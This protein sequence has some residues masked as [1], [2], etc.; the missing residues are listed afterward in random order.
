MKTYTGYA[1]I[2]QNLRPTASTSGTA[3]A[4]IPKNA[5]MA[6]SL[7]EGDN[8]WLAATYNGIS[9]FVS[10]RN[11][12]ILDAGATCEVTG[13]AAYVRRTPESSATLL[14]MSVNGDIL[15]LLDCTTV[16]GWYRVSTADG[17]GWTPASNL[18][19]IT[20]PGED[21]EEEPV[22][23]TSFTGMV[24]RDA[25]PL[26]DEPIYF[27]T[28]AQDTQLTV[29]VIEPDDEH[30][31]DAYP[32]WFIASDYDYTGYIR[33]RYIG[34]TDAG[35]TC[36]V[37]AETADVYVTPSTDAAILYAVESGEVLQLLDTQYA[38]GWYRV[39]TVAGTGWIQTSCVTGES[40]DGSDNSGSGSEGSEGSEGET[41]STTVDFTGMS[42]SVG[43]SG[44]DVY[45]Y[46]QKP[47]LDNHYYYGKDPGTF[48]EDTMWAVK[49]FQYKN[50]WEIT[51]CDGVADQAV[52]EKLNGQDGA[53]VA[54]LSANV[55]DRIDNEI[56]TDLTM[57]HPLWKAHPFDA[58]NTTNKTEQIGDSGNAPAAIAIAFSAL[59]GLAITPPVIC[60]EALAHNWRDHNGITGITSSFWAGIA[61][62]HGMT[63]TALG[64]S[65]TNLTNY[66]ANG[67][68]ALI[69]VKDDSEHDYCSDG[70]ATYL[71]VYKVENGYIYLQNANDRSSSTAMPTS[72]VSNKKDWVLQLY[73]F[74][75]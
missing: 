72:Y 73:G 74:K 48:D 69:R 3:L 4:S 33:A 46:V 52:L 35:A 32:D 18:T 71:V 39:S 63:Y 14:Y 5:E 16:E 11:V 61:N 20:A 50:G 36:S 24:N 56:P 64:T 13:S 58:T 38:E 44:D 9:G 1:V 60:R 7:V 26:Q 49:Y 25:A 41:G 66:C 10:A 2:T 40:E 42:F 12:A 23:R 31:P 17:T 70:G 67:G 59:T 68:I 21:E 22:V 75:A 6:V 30:Y 53:L 8:A 27:S 34:V 29:H 15:Q 47:L 57:D 62:L 65:T 55:I 45:N 37:S 28:L 54:G 43:D 51:D 19:I